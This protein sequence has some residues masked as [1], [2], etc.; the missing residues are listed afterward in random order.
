MSMFLLNFG[1]FWRKI[2]SPCSEMFKD[3]N[4]NPPNQS[5]QTPLSSCKQ[6]ASNFN[7]NRGSCTSASP[8]LD[9]PADLFSS[10]DNKEKTLLPINRNSGAPLP[11]SF[12][13]VT[14]SGSDVVVYDSVYTSQGCRSGSLDFCYPIMSLFKVFQVL[15]DE[16]L[17]AD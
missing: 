1:E 12:S 5:P 4:H 16:E 13:I 14:T 6:N 7:L 10:L 8:C 17:D 2:R 3:I 15:R 9:Q 11:F